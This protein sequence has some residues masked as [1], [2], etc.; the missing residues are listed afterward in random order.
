MFI[1]HRTTYACID[2]RIFFFFF[3]SVFKIKVK[4]D[5]V[6][7][8]NTYIHIQ[9]NVNTVSIKTVF[10]FKWFRYDI[11]IYYL[12]CVGYKKYVRRLV[13]VRLDTYSAL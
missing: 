1:F 13:N 6:I 5:H 12:K 9:T 8:T 10:T 11:I 3:T 2:V 4:F 7:Y